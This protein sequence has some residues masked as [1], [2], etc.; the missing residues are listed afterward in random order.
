MG[1][2]EDLAF[3]PSRSLECFDDVDQ[4]PNPIDQDWPLTVQVIGE[5]DM[6]RI[7]GE[8]D[9]RHSGASVRDRKHD[10]PPEHI[11]QVGGLDANLGSR[12]IEEVQV[13]ERELIQNFSPAQSQDGTA[14]CP[15]LAERSEL[16]P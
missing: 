8:S 2:F 4:R 11:D 7:V 15:C 14:P 10:S 1:N 13:L 9:H 12:H 3:L 16:A 5:K 6:R